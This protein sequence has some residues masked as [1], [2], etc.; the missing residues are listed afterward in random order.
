MAPTSTLTKTA[1]RTVLRVHAQGDIAVST[2]NKY[3]AAMEHAY[4]SSFVFD[5]LVEQASQIGQ[6][7]G[8]RPPLPISAILWH[9]WWPPTPSKIAAFV[10]D[11]Q[12]L[13]LKGVVLQSPGFW[14]FVGSLNPL[15]MLLTYLN[16]R[17]ERQ[18]DNDYRNL[19][20][21]R[22]LALENQLLENQVI[23]QRTAIL[24]DLGATE[25][26]LA[27]LKSQLLRQPL[28]ELSIFQDQRLIAGVE[29]S[30]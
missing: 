25:N 23:T 14:D 2:I 21:A 20:E 10:P 19:A 27:V 17:H 7:T 22:K 6:S 4:N 11:D 13:I 1:D 30:R 8:N 12:K 28:Q 18:K 24:K 5:Q 15:Q 3:L 29:L 16:E 26:D 9:S